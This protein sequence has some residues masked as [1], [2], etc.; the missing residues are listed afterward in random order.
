VKII[1]L[2]YIGVIIKYK[3]K[4]GK[5]LI[6]RFGGSIGYFEITIYMKVLALFCIAVVS[7]ATQTRADALLLRS[8]WRTPEADLM[9][10]G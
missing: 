6:Q 5:V 7:L 9:P 4:Y 3:K 8:R 2:Q 10:V 1:F